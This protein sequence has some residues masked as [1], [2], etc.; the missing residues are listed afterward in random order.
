MSETTDL[1]VPLDGELLNWI[2]IIKNIALVKNMKIYGLPFVF[3][4]DKL[5][6]HLTQN[7]IFQPQV[8]NVNKLKENVI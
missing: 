4:I 6:T 8:A 3:G 5:I 1:K 7:P 2:K